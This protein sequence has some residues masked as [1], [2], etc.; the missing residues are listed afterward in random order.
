LRF[1]VRFDVRL[2]V[3]I[4]VDFACRLDFRFRFRF[5][6]GT[7]VE[8]RLVVVPQR[9]ARPSPSRM[10]RRLCLFVWGGFDRLRWLRLVVE[11]VRGGGRSFFDEMGC[12]RPVFA[13]LSNFVLGFRYGF[14]ARSERVGP[15]L[16]FLLGPS[17]GFRA[18]LSFGFRTSLSLGFRTSLSLGFRASLSFGFRTSLSLGFRTSL[19]LGFRTSLS[20]GFRTGLSFCF[21]ASLSFGFGALSGFALGLRFGLGVTRG[22]VFV[23][24][25]ALV[26]GYRGERCRFGFRRSGLRARMRVELIAPCIENFVAVSAAGEPA[27]HREQG[28]L[29][30]ENRFAVRTA[31]G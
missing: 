19:S 11:Y 9:F 2:A 18:S 24:A 22:R 21:S 14:G 26:L 28:F 27:G 31:S 12:V 4:G 30:A 25:S 16:G 13:V 15:F 10:G 29:H 8:M 20:F 17:F 3:G 1:D 23:I 6:R 5:G 7:A